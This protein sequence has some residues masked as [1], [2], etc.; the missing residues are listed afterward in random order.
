LGRRAAIPSGDRTV[1]P[2]RG[3]RTVEPLRGYR[4]G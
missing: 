4:A 1:E 3:Y 2:L